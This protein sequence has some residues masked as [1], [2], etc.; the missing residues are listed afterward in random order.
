MKR[1]KE[2]MKR[3]ILSK[4]LAIAVL[5]GIKRGIKRGQNYFIF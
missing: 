1:S 2:P 3:S 4:W 5:L